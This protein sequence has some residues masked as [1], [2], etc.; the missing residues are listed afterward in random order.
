MFACLLSQL[1]LLCLIADQAVT[2]V[3]EG[4]HQGWITPSLCRVPLPAPVS[5]GNARALHRDAV[6]ALDFLRSPDA[7]LLCDVINALAGRR[8]IS[9]AKLQALARLPREAT[10]RGNEIWMHIRPEAAEQRRAA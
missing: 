6:E 3:R 10:H 2:D 1:T 5:H 7:E 8:V 4:V 9:Q